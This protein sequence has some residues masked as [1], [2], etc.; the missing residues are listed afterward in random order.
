MLKKQLRIKILKYNKNLFYIVV[1]FVK[2][3]LHS[4]YFEKIGVCFFRKNKKIIMLS[5]RRLVY[6]L[7]HGVSITK[8][9]SYLVSIIFIFYIKNKKENDLI[10][11]N[12]NLKLL[13]IKNKSKYYDKKL[14][15]DSFNYKK[16]NN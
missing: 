14:Y 9:V 2:R 13:Q 11:L 4:R 10:F 16:V 15:I 8:L 6:W 5:I 7:N 3:S 1:A 12:Y